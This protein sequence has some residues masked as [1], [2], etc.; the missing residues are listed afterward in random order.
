MSPR[1]APGR[2]GEHGI[3]VLPARKFG[4]RGLPRLLLNLVG[5]AVNVVYQ[6]ANPNPPD[7]SAH[8]LVPGAPPLAS[9]VAGPAALPI[10]FRSCDQLAWLS[11]DQI[12]APLGLDASS[13]TK[14]A[15]FYCC[16]MIR[17][18]FLVEFKFIALQ[19]G[20]TQIAGLKKKR[21][22]KFE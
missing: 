2:C 3:H 16:W 1:V 17:N 21:K 15:F 12:K 8:D 10:V 7:I 14:I 6:Q 22:R 5:V 18:N 11:P 20:L 19:T 13:P 9:A 4:E